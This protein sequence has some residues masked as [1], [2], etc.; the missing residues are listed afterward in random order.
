M[1]YRNKKVLRFFQQ[2]FYSIQEKIRFKT[3]HISFWWKITMLWVLLCFIALF[4]PW[5][6]PIDTLTP[7]W[8]RNI[9][10]SLSFS[11]LLGF[12]GVFIIIILSIITFSICSIQKKE[13]F[14]FFSMLQ[15]SDYLSAMFGWIFIFILSL[16]SFFFINGLRFF[17]INILYWQGI[18]L[19]ITGSIIIFIGAILLKKEQRKNIKWSYVSEL[20]SPWNKI[21]NKEGKR[22]MKLP[23]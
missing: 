14:H 4:L 2:L 3:S 20:H 11:S 22:N 7:S 15:L 13:K 18:I 16:H 21:K 23:F 9:P 8:S 17:S 10:V 1:S 5:I 6:L 19:S 12:V